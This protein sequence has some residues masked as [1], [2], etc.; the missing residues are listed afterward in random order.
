MNIKD[1][2]KVITGLNGD[3]YFTSEEYCE[4]FYVQN[5]EIVSI[6]ATEIVENERYGCYSCVQIDGIGLT[7]SKELF[8]SLSFEETKRKLI[9]S[10]YDDLA[11]ARLVVK[12]L[13]EK[14]KELEENEYYS[15]RL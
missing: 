12:E 10:K 4:L 15:G 8:P 2:C 5:N 13:E 14:I 1:G 7:I 3:V 11:K 9:E 6:E